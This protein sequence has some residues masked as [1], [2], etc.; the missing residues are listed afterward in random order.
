M[1]SWENAI[2]VHDDGLHSD[3]FACGFKFRQEKDMNLG[4]IR[5]Y[6]GELSPDTMVSAKELW[7]IFNAFTPLMTEEQEKMLITELDKVFT[8]NYEYE[9]HKRKNRAHRD[10][11]DSWSYFK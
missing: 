10:C 4:F 7:K 2:C 1:K 8:K 9:G 3:C 11:Q 6:L 5:Q